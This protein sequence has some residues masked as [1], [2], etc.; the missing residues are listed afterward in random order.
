ME[1]IGE[2]ILQ[3]RKQVESLFS[4]KYGKVVLAKGRLI[5]NMYAPVVLE[6]EELATFPL[7]HFVMD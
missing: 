3:L 1:D 4:I 6:T 5:P 7:M 2:M